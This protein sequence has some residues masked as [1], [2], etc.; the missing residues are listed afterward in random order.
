MWFRPRSLFLFAWFSVLLLGSLPGRSRA[1][2]DL[3]EIPGSAFAVVRFTSID[4]VA[5]GTTDMLTAL[6]P[7]GA[8]ASSSIEPGLQEIL[9][10]RNP[11]GPLGDSIDRSKPVYV[12][13][14]PLFDATDA[15]IAVLLHPRDETKLQRGLLLASEGET[16]TAQDVGQGWSKISKGAQAWYFSKRG[17]RLIYTNFEQ[18][19]KFFVDGAQ[20]PKFAAEVQENGLKTFSEGEVGLLV[21]AA[22]LNTRFKTE[23]EKAKQDTLRGIEGLD[24]AALGG[25]AVDPQAIKKTYTELAKMAF[26]AVSESRWVAAR[27]GISSEGFSGAATV[28]FAAEG[29]TPKLLAE[30]ASSSLENVGLM[31][32]GMPVYMAVQ[33]GKALGANFENLSGYLPGPG[34][35]ERAAAQALIDKSEPGPQVYGF[36]LPLGPN[37]GVVI[38]SLRQAADSSLL[39]AGTRALLKSAVETK[40]PL[41]TQSVEYR[42]NVE[43]Y[44]EHDIDIS[45]MRMAFAESTDAGSIAG[46]AVARKM[47]G[48]DGLQTRVTAIEGFLVQVTGNDPGLLP[49]MLD[50]LESG[51]KVT[52]LDASFGKTRDKLGEQA[53]FVA[54]FNV[55]QMILDMVKLIRDIP[56]ID[57]VLRQVPLNFNMQP[58]AAYVGFSAGAEPQ[59][60][61]LHLFVPISQPRDVLKI[62]GGL[63]GAGG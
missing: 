3:S 34:S 15:P 4:A 63:I 22:Q 50:G 37:T 20:G 14:F 36:S 10:L 29:A 12:A 41:F 56:P 40:S 32:A 25:A 31:P 7:L 57:M 49:R 45:T 8:R 61:R 26:D 62:F 30:N 5:R 23:I 42:E 2:D 24:A 19:M 39:L 43:K 58:E 6:G 33:L 18:V 54:M 35:A 46:Q 52:G 53:N 11:M 16:L 13:F 1:D 55:P 38:S 17:E 47:L 44:K 21:D 51:E 28:G 59:A 48:A 27:A 9:G 60:L